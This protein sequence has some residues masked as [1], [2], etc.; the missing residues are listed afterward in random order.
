[1]NRHL[2]FRI[3]EPNGHPGSFVVLLAGSNGP[4]RPHSPTIVNK[5]GKQSR[6]GNRLHSIGWRS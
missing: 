4:E 2:C 1:M 5:G 3:V 6:V